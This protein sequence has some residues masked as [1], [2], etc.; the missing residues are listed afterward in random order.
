MKTINH[1][2]PRRLIVGLVAIAVLATT[3][4]A[5]GSIKQKGATT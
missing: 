2:K 1:S 5:V 4:T 3:A